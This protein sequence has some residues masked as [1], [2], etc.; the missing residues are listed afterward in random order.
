MALIH[1]KVFISQ[2][3]LHSTGGPDLLK[4]GLPGGGVKSAKVALTPYVY[5]PPEQVTSVPAAE[6]E[7]RSREPGQPRNSGPVHLAMIYRTQSHAIYL[8]IT[9]NTGSKDNT[10]RS[11][12]KTRLYR[13]WRGLSS[14]A[15]H[16]HSNAREPHGCEHSPPFVVFHASSPW[17]IM[18]LSMHLACIL[19]ASDEPAQPASEQS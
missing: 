13:S 1:K 12:R 4:W 19:H 10:S 5:Y 16:D 2:K 9:L 8:T 14:G 18:H 6:R 17:L 11:Q 7:S 15:P 3:G